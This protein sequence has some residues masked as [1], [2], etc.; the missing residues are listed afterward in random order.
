MSITLLHETSTLSILILNM[1]EALVTST[2]TIR[3]FQ[4][5]IYLLI[6]Y[7]LY[8]VRQTWVGRVGIYPPTFW[9]KQY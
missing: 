2:S 4:A 7:I 9:P 1:C 5:V 3:S 8:Q 6:L